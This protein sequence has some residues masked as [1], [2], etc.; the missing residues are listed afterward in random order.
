MC[1]RYSFGHVS[2]GFFSTLVG[3]FL[4]KSL[5]FGAVSSVEGSVSWTALCIIK[6]DLDLTWTGR[7]LNVDSQ[8]RFLPVEEE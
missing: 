5:R 4:E 8:L 1:I 7:L 3:V 2:L 6:V